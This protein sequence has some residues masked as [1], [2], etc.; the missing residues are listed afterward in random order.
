MGLSGRFIGFSVGRDSS[1]TGGLWCHP[2]VPLMK[3]NIVSLGILK[4]VAMYL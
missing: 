3:Q 4:L 2:K 1:N